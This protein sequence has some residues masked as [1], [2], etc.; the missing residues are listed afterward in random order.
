MLKSN[1]TKRDIAGF[2]AVANE[3]VIRL[4]SDMKSEGVIDT[5]GKK[6]FI[7]DVDQLKAIAQG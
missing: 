2:L 5:Q 3:T 4:M 1:L 6:I 7:R